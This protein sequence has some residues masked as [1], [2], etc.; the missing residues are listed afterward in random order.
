MVDPKNHMREDFIIDKNDAETEAED[1]RREEY[2]GQSGNMFRKK[3]YLPFI[4]GAAALVVLVII[5]GVVFSGR[6]DSADRERLQSLE[7]RIGQLENKLETMGTSDQIPAQVARLQQELST[8]GKRLNGFESTVSTQID[9]IIKE[10]GALHQK[11]DQAPAARAQALPA[12]E[13]KTAA[14]A[15][16][17]SAAA[18]PKQSPAAKFYQVQAGDTL[19]RISRRFGLTV[20][21]LQRYNNITPDAAIHPGQ[22]LRLTPQTT[23]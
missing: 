2:Y 8:M 19:Y 12:A 16:K 5:L 3:S 11:L 23:P 18:A 7:A 6:N 13:K 9:Q 4:I 1:F 20:E 21:Q 10:L 15:P 22:K 14:A 17:K